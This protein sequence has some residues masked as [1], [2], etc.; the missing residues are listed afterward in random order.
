MKCYLLGGIAVALTITA[1][2]MLFDVKPDFSSELAQW[3][4]SMAGTV[5]V[6]CLIGS[7]F[8]KP[9]R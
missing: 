7:L 6:L 8:M 4:V 3:F 9:F 5:A 1:V 2:C